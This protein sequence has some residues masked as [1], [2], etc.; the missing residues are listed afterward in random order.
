MSD[1]YIIMSRDAQ[2]FLPLHN[3]WFHILL[4]LVGTDQH[5]YGIM[6]EV[7]DRTDGAVRLWPATLYGSL[8][9]LIGDGL[10]EE[11]D[12]RPA[13]ELDDARRR[14]Y[15]LTRLGRTVLDLECERLQ[16]MVKM[17]QR[18]RKQEAY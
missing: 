5:G 2:D 12:E 7:L 16:D 18:K 11:S 8:K 1:I 6:Q 15:R 13:A 14:Y 3:N 10:I 4:T 17:M 9:R